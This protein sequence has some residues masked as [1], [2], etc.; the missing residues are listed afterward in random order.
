[1][2]SNGHMAHEIQGT[3]GEIHELARYG[4]RSEAL[5]EV[6]A[7]IQDFVAYV[8][9]NEGGALRLPAGRCQHGIQARVKAPPPG[10][11]QQNDR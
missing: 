7:A 2:R 5:T 10:Y 4:I 1:M 11:G 9:A 3:P 6:L 8:R